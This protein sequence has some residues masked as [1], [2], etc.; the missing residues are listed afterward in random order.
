M[1]LVGLLLATSLACSACRSKALAPD[2]LSSPGVA[3][4]QA[5]PTVR[6]GKGNGE[7]RFVAVG[8]TG[9]GGKGQ[10]DVAH[11]IDAT[12]KQYGCDFVLLLG[13]NFYETGVSSVEDSLFR[14][15]FEEPYAALSMPF[16][17][18]L[19][20]HDYGA[21]GAGLDFWRATFQVQYTS[22]S[23][24]WRMPA[25]YYHFEKPVGTAAL[26]AQF[27]GLDTQMILLGRAAVQ[28]TD[29][30]AWIRQS[31]AKWK[32]AFGH[33]PYISNGP[34]GNAGEYNGIP[35]FGNT[36][37]RFFDETICGKVDFYFAGHDHT[38][39]YLDGGCAGTSFF[40]SGAGSAPTHN[41]TKN[42][43]F[44]Q[45]AE[46]GFLYGVLLDDEL[47]VS[48]V[49]ASSKINYSR[50]YRKQQQQQHE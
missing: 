5:T 46:L 33:H 6:A 7:L 12:C 41:T 8:D 40:V 23:T 31:T 24:K 35:L 25:E 21:N 15:R 44:Y 4:A 36:V 14:T 26:S 2:P 47:S 19:G 50:T 9:K 28:R 18:V 22:R 34:H 49:D 1:R 27:I 3:P 13:D 37:K 42:R 32:I 29:T 30:S 16:Y 45:S 48:A 39:Q 43:T 17:A 11:A 38:L 20:N 10:L